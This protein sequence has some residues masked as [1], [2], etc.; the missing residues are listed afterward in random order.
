MSKR[1]KI[2]WLIMIAASIL[3][4][5]WGC[6]KPITPQ[7][8]QVLPEGITILFRDVDIRIE[9]SNRPRGRYTLNG[10]EL[11]RWCPG[12]GIYY[13]IIRGSGILQI[14]TDHDGFYEY[15]TYLK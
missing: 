3:L 10:E 2:Y 7:P 6:S 14:D 9:T 1:Q 4:N 15:S 11:Q 8:A 12:D 5:T 13:H